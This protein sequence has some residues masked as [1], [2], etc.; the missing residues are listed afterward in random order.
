L[1][2]G[3][4]SSGNKDA[5]GAQCVLCN[6]ILSNSSL[7]SAKLQKHIETNHSEYKDKGISLFKRKLES[8]KKSKLSM[9][10]LVKTDNKNATEAS[11]KV[12]YRISLAGE[13]HTTGESLI[14]P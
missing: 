12:S 6:K 11:Y 3:F 5:P 10:K 4:T 14:K 9:L 13:E 1:S 8:L 2:Y 7:V